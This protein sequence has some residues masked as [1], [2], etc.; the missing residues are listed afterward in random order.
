MKNIGLYTQFV[1]KIM[2]MHFINMLTGTSVNDGIH[3]EGA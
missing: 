2:D 3:K 1:I